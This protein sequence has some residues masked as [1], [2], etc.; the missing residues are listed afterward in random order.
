MFATLTLDHLVKRKKKKKTK[1]AFSRGTFQ[2]KKSVHV[3]YSIRFW[4][5]VENEWGGCVIPLS[6]F[7]WM[8]RWIDRKMCCCLC[9]RL[10]IQ[11]CCIFCG[12]E[13]RHGRYQSFSRQRFSHVYFIIHPFSVSLLL[14]GA[15]AV[16]LNSEFS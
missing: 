9:D 1:G 5:S 3:K 8:F 6:H 4:V 14:P 11:T 15:Q 16:I 12:C 13:R 10:Q 2:L 7:I